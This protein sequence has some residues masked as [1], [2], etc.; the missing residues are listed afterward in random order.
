MPLPRYDKAIDIGFVGRMFHR[1][2]IPLLSTQREKY[3]GV[4]LRTRPFGHRGRLW[5]QAIL[6]PPHPIHHGFGVRSPQT[7]PRLSCSR[8]ARADRWCRPASK[9]RSEG[10]GV[11]ARRDTSARI[12]RC[13]R[14]K[15]SRTTVTSERFWEEPKPLRG[16]FGGFPSHSFERSVTLADRTSWKSDAGLH[17]G[18]LPSLG[19]V[20][21]RSGWT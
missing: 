4:T 16:V 20:D 6:Q 9:S 3:C 17:V 18:R 13:G 8:E 21:G 11:N 2:V 1:S 15:P 5:V 7:R 19:V 14:N 12:W 10:W